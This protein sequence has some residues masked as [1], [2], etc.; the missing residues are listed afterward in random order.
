MR[1]RRHLFNALCLTSS[2]LRQ[3]L[4]L[5]LSR[6]LPVVVAPLTLLALDRASR[7]SDSS[8]GD[9]EVSPRLAQAQLYSSGLT[10]CSSSPVSS[11]PLLAAVGASL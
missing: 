2:G 7:H 5:L 6:L 1:D 9:Q 3:H 10:M 8:Q 11:Q 4:L